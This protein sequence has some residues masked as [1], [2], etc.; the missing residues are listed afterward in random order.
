MKLATKAWRLVTLG[1]ITL[2]YDSLTRPAF[3]QN[4][5]YEEESFLSGDY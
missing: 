4:H 3:A 5:P 2:S 1:L